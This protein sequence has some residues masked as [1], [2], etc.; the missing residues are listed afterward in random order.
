MKEHL[1]DYTAH[2]EKTIGEYMNHPVTERSAEAVKGMTECWE[3]LKAAEKML[4]AGGYDHMITHDDTKMWANKMVNDDGTTDDGADH[5][6]SKRCR[7]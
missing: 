6:R 7:R 5:S 4:A 2:L 3:H 1:K